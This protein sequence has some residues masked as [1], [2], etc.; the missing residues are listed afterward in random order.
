[1]PVKV[2]LEN[3]FLGNILLRRLERLAGE[4]ETDHRDDQTERTEQ[5]D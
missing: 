5:T 3:P 2:H 4:L 1:M